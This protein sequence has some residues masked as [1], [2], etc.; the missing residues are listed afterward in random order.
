VPAAVS[1]GTMLKRLAGL[2]DTKD[3]SV[4][5]TNFVRDQ[6]M[7]TD[8]GARTAHLSGNQV[9]KIEQIFSKHFAG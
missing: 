9:S 3:L 1:V 5:E 7:R 4:W 2:V 8:Q 6:L